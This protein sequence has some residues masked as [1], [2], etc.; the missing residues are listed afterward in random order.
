PAMLSINTVVGRMSPKSCRKH[1]SLRRCSRRRSNRHSFT[2]HNHAKVS[3]G[4]REARR[5]SP[6]YITVVTVHH[7]TAGLPIPE[8]GSSCFLSG[9]G[10]E[11]LLLQGDCPPSLLCYSVHGV[12]KSR[13]RSAISS[14]RSR[15]T[16]CLVPSN[17]CN[18]EWGIS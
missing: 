14:A 4:E 1:P 6:R 16:A 11:N 18:S 17:A 12:S 3:R 7:P 10:M 5:A 8:A 13:I 9:S 15:C 2:C